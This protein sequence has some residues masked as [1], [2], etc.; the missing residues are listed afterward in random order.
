M[1]VDRNA[2]QAAMVEFLRALGHDPA[3]HPELAGTAA[4]VVE[5][6]ADDFLSGEGVDLGALIHAGRV[7]SDAATGSNLVVLRDLDVATLCPHHLTPALGRATVGYV[8]GRHLIGV[9]T[10]AR[11]VDACARRLTLQE[12]LGELVVDTLMQ[13]AGARGAFCRLTLR[14]G[15]L[16]ARGAR[17][18]DAW[19]ETL[20][21]AGELDSPERL[22]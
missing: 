16:C 15:C 11:L 4:H 1:T 3:A 7:E 8:P 9:G 2:A 19:L 14:H 6:F 13:H 21:H 17:Q 5:A 12:R 18:P 20:A 22:R 10:L